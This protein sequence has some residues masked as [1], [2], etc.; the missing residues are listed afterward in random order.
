MTGVQTCAL[1]ILLNNSQLGIVQEKVM[2]V[3]GLDSWIM[4]GSQMIIC[5]ITDKHYD[6]IIHY[7]FVKR[8]GEWL[9]LIDEV[10]FPNAT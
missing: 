1:P 10:R 8:K 5:F 6:N 3:D 2:K 9:P 4:K 7:W